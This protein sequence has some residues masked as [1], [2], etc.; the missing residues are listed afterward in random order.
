MKLEILIVNS[1]SSRVPRKFLQKWVTSCVREIHKHVPAKHARK[2]AGELTLVF[3]SK[4]QAR[5]INRD[6]RGRDYATDVLS[7]ESE[8][9]FGELI[10]CAEVLKKQAKDHGL[11]YQQEL[12][13]MVLHGVLHLLGYD[14]ERGPRQ[15]RRMFQIQD[16]IFRTL[17]KT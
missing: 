12:G 3:L 15:A 13:Y 14:H 8:T 2:L 5:R 9:G 11:R 6:F 16:T 10:L 1:G 17:T 4:A 7:F